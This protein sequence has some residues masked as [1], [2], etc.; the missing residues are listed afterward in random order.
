MQMMTIFGQK[1]ILNLIN[2]CMYEH[3]ETSN[4]SCRCSCF[5]ENN[6]PFRNIAIPWK[7][8]ESDHYIFGH[9]A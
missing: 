5:L 2:S 3:K 6:R 8:G 9:L 1:L 7:Y 4:L